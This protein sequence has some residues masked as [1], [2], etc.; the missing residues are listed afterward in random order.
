MQSLPS[1]DQRQTVTFFFFNSIQVGREPLGIAGQRFTLP[2]GE[3]AS[4]QSSLSRQLQAGM[5]ASLLQVTP[6]LPVPTPVPLCHLS[7]ATLWDRGWHQ[8]GSAGVDGA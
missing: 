1:R 2:Q 6:S 8:D 7:D 3:T 5:T 4:A